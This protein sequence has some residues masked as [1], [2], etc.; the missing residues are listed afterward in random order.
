[1]YQ[2]PITIVLKRRYDQIVARYQRMYEHA[3][4]YGLEDWV[5]LLSDLLCEICYYH[6]FSW[7]EIPL[8]ELRCDQL[9][10]YAFWI[11]QTYKI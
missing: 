3:A 8:L 6:E 2:E 5:N 11:Q 1:M 10:H 7:F 9:D 4:E